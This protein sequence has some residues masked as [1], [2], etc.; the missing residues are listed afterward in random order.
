MLHN[1]RFCT[2]CY[3]ITYRKL[4]FSCKHVTFM[5]DIA[6]LELYLRKDWP[7]QFIKYVFIIFFNILKHKVFMINKTLT[8]R[9]ENILPRH[10]LGPFVA[11]ICISLN[12]RLCNAINWVRT[13]SINCIRYL[14]TL[15]LEN[16]TH[17]HV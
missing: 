15:G 6:I 9:I 16:F 5:C 1:F 4:L 13:L 14:R 17:P 10:N 8:C 12:F 3:N 11:F 2:V 7:V